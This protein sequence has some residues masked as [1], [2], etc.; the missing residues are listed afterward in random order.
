MS[1]LVYI[2][3]HKGKI[4]KSSLEAVS[5]A[6]N[7][8]GQTSGTVTAIT[9]EGNEDIYAAIGNAGADK[10]LSIKNETLSNGF[11]IKGLAEAVAQSIET[12]S[13]SVIVFPFDGSGQAV[14]PYVASLKKAGII[15]G[16]TSYPTIKGDAFEITK[17]VFSGK[18]TALYTISS[19]IKVISVLPNSLP[20]EKT[21]KTASVTDFSTTISDG[22]VVLKQFK[23]NEDVAHGGVP[24]PD[25]ELVVS[26]GRG[27]KGPENWGIVEDL[28]HVLGAATACSRPVSDADWRP[29]HEHVGQTGIAIRPNLYIA[30]GISGAI[31]HLAGVNG[32][33]TIVVI[34]NDPEAPFFK[35]ADYGI[36]GDALKVVPK[37]TEAIKAFKA[38]S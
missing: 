13:A 4:K 15:S 21:G 36:V 29:H 23:V 33:K 30:I 12:E 11:N 37:L 8:A 5:Y 16:A 6:A 28:A 27:L 25:A 19:P 38:K 31:Q 1:V 3:P 18:A 35:N 26:G 7:I 32:S 17:N 14:A 9:F 22:G 20:V 2:E 10:I 24:L 34:N